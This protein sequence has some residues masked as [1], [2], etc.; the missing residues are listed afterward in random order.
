LNTNIPNKE[1]ENIKND[2]KQENFLAVLN[3]GHIFHSHCIV[4]WNSNHNSCPICRK[5][6]EDDN[7][8]ELVREYNDNQNNNINCQNQNTNLQVNNTNNDLFERIW[9]VQTVMHPSLNSYNYNYNY[10]NGF[11]WL[12]PVSSN[13][14]AAFETNFLN[15][16]DSIG[17]GFGD[18]GGGAS[19]DW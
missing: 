10:D 3:C 13:Y 15:R 7:D 11:T 6:I 9:F 14:S 17:G 2:K 8:K 4:S 19:D 5:K 16:Y 18:F 12:P 1:V